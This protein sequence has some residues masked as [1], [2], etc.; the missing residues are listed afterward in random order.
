MEN[1]NRTSMLLWFLLSRLKLST[2]NLSLVALVPTQTILLPPHVLNNSGMSYLG[3]EFS[4]LP[5]LSTCSPHRDGET[6]F[7]CLAFWFFA[8]LPLSVCLA[9]HG[10][11]NQPVVAQGKLLP[12]MVE[13]CWH[14]PVP[15]ANTSSIYGTNTL[16]LAGLHLLRDTSL[17]YTDYAYL[18]PAGLFVLGFFYSQ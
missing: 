16:L 10:C 2:A 17:G 5:Y 11:L 18:P 1:I 9:L 12:C 14:F 6:P 15:I 7:T 13:Q 4:A 8:P 3:L